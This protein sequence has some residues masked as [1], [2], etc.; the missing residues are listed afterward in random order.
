MAI[1]ADS[2][3]QNGASDDHRTMAQR[4]AARL[5]DL[6]AQDQLGPGDRIRERD[7]AEQLSVSRTPLR[8]ALRILAAERLVELLPN[9]GAVV[10]DPSQKE[11]QDLLSMLGALEALAGEQAAERASD[12]QIDEVRA[13]HYEM[14]AAFSRQDRL[15][16]FHLNQAIHRAIVEASGN[17]ALIET[18]ALTNARLYR[19]RYTSNLVNTHWRV[20]V[21]EHESIIEALAARDGE[22]LSKILR[23]HLGSTWKNIRYRLPSGTDSAASG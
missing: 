6:I 5:R 11:I 4:V 15:A 3:R 14:L 21:S 1:S 12:A 18:H 20:A 8:E 23:A 16:Y 22:R 17:S 9:R 10:A 2:S 13:L 19:V 7:L